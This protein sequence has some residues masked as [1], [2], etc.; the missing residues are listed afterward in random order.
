MAV[1][2]SRMMT[3]CKPQSRY[4]LHSASPMPVLRSSA[5]HYHLVLLVLRAGQQALDNALRSSRCHN[6][7]Y[8]A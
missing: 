1:L 6:L 3:E 2:K 7:P 8:P 5:T 4:R